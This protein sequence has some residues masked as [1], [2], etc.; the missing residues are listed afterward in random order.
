MAY[1]KTIDLYPNDSGVFQTAEVKKRSKLDIILALAA[2][3]VLAGA[4]LLNAIVG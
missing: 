3:T 1:D 4:I 2:L